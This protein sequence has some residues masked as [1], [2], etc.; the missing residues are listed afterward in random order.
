M[1][2]EKTSAAL[3]VNIASLQ[4][5]FAGSVSVRKDIIK[6]PYMKLVQTTSDSFKSRVADGGEFFCKSTAEHFGNKLSFIPL[7]ISESAS[8]MDENTKSP[9]CKSLDLKKN[10]NGEYCHKCP[11]NSYWNDWSGGAPKCKTAI[12][13]IVLIYRGPDHEYTRS[14]VVQISFRKAA[15]A[16]GKEIVNMVS[17]D[18]YKVPFGSVYTIA[19][20]LD[21][22]KGHDFYNIDASGIIKVQLTEPEL[23]KVIPVAREL[24]EARKKGTLHTEEEHDEVSEDD[25]LPV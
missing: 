16:A 9:L 21:K 2:L 18:A 3:S 1:E 13:M 23:I 12:D 20:K 14:D 10:T 6:I 17:Y 25:S 4:N 5:E 24:N 11:H 7:S 22:G 8:L 19:S 15:H